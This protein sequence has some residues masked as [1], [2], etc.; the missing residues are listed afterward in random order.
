MR[1]QKRMVEVES[2]RYDIAIL[3]QEKLQLS[4]QVYDIESELLEE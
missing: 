4:Q 3:E 2:L 1:L